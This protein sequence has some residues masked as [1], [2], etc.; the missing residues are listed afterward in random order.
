MRIPRIYHPE[1]LRDHDQIDLSD[2]GAGHVA[3][4]LR[5]TTG[6]PIT[7]FCGDGYDYHG[8]ILELTKRSV[9]VQ[10]N[11]REDQHHLESPLNIHLGQVM[12]RGDKMDFTIQKSVELGVIAI[13]PLLSERCGVKL[14]EKRLEKKRQQWQK[15]VVSAC[16]QCG[17]A[18]VP[19]V[20][21]VIS[22]EQ[23]SAQPTPA[24]KLNLHPKAPYTIK[25]M[26]TPTHGIRLLIG[27]EGGLSDDEIN[28]CSILAFSEIQLG[29][30]ILRTETAALTAIS[31]LQCQFGDLAQ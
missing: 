25:S 14:D 22:L 4:V 9:S 19:I 18:V 17:R 2:D 20:H 10:I 26:P 28:R 24:L 5:L 21:E 8:E 27:P 30:R 13:T 31:A 3:R 29:P 12:S 23:W 7:L 6:H 11:T 16:E 15:V 1:P